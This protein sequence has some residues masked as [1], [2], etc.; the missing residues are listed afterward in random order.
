MSPKSACKTQQQLPINALVHQYESLVDAGAHLL[1]NESEFAQLIEYYEK[2]NAL[3]KALE[4]ISHALNYYKDAAYFYVCR[5]KLLIKAR[6]YEKALRNLR[7]AEKL[8][9]EAR[10]IDLLRAQICYLDRDYP[11]TLEVLQRLRNSDLPEKE[12]V[13]VWLLEA[14][15]RKHLDEPQE[16]LEALIEILRVQPEH[17]R[18]LELTTVAVEDNKAFDWA[19]RYFKAHTDRFPYSYLGWYNLGYA[20]HNKLEYQEAMDAFEF[21]YTIAPEY[22]PA[23]Q[24]YIQLCFDH[25]QFDKA[26]K[27][28][29]EYLTVFTDDAEMMA[30][31]GECYLHLGHTDK[32]RIML[33]RALNLEHQSD[34]VYFAI[35]ASYEQE[36][37]HGV[38]SHFF[39]KTIKMNAM[40]EDAW[41]GLGRSLYKQGMGERAIASLHRATALAPEVTQIWVQ[42]IAT[43]L[44]QG[45]IKDALHVCEEAD[46]SAYGADLLYAEAAVYWLDGQEVKA[47]DLL[48]EAMQE[49]LKT[50]ELF[51]DLAPGARG[52]SKLTA[53]FRYYQ[54]EAVG[55]A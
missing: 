45:K 14:L 32:A 52:N 34:D 18:A 48:A 15:V 26:L 5:A 2:G 49:D 53:M 36:G 21:S 27:A 30:L 23:Y 41:L 22:G 16:M 47:V 43:Y 38:A 31:A 3:N 20:L 9:Y 4:A 11:A 42:L 40:R 13:D 44:D 19:V 12:L 35:A 29:L 7:M 37:N 50:V 1:F 10:Y 24:E 28:A 51:Y 8:G 6:K 54:S 17:K 46:Q 33:F 39:K 55:V 25:L